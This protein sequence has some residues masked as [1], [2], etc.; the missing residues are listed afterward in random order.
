[1]ILAAGKGERMHPLT[2]EVP[3]ALLRVGDKTLVDWTIRR[4]SDAGISNIVVAIGWKGSQ[5]EDHL[6]TSDSMVKI[7]QVADYE[8]G[9]LQTLLTAIDTFDDDFLLIPVDTFTD[10]S[11]LSSMISHYRKQSE[12]H[13]TTLAVDLESTSGTP[14][15]IRENGSV[16]GIG[17]RAS[18][19]ETMSRS[20]MLFI[21]NSRI[22]TDCKKALDAGE[23]KLVSV[24]NQRIRDGR[25]IR[26]Y[27]VKSSS[28]DI[29][30]LSDLLE[31]NR[32]V[33]E[34]GD[35]SQVGQVFVP[36]HDS[37]EVG[38]I[39]RLK[40]HTTLHKGT[41][42]I[43]PVLISPGCKIGERCRIGPHVTL[44]SNST[45][46]TD[47]DIS[48]SVVFGES[49]ISSQSRLQGTIVYKSKRYNVER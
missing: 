2:E 33:L 12:P 40:S 13:R 22:K 45:L 41:E 39:L 49:T 38:D 20:A 15:S 7:V 48:N 8:T 5:V 26:S 27:P 47:C 43:G 35:F 36:P 34:R 37:I 44:D 25:V 19:A 42:I 30:R 16:S 11:I 24:L 23:T 3:K 29:D 31:A 28:I 4:L 32:L 46:L 6:S 9:P 17:N 18:D 10:S 14:V 21:G 1:V